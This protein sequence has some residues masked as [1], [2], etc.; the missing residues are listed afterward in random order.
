[1]KKILWV[2]IL[3][4][5]VIPA[6]AA[7]TGP[8]GILFAIGGGRRPDAMMKKFI[9]L[10]QQHKSGRIIVLPMASSVP[11]EV[12]PEQAD[13]L[14]LLGADKAE[15]R[16]LSP[17]D[18]MKPETASLFDDA[19]GVFFSGGVQS[20]LAD[21][22]MGTVVHRKLKTIYNQGAVIGGTSAGAAVMS[23]MMITGDE[24]FADEIDAFATIQADNIVTATGLGF[25]QSV[26]IDQH[27]I[28]RKRHNRLIS[29][30]L[31]NPNKLG[32]GIDESTAAVIFPDQIFTVLGE[33]NIIVY[34][35]ADAVVDQ[36]PGLALSGHNLLLH[37]LKPGDRYN[38][39]TRRIV[40]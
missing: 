20:R 33:R 25:S 11:E 28:R 9:E 34:D 1:M 10:A 18:V 12:G 14:R 15:S 40:K 36:G 8:K 16:I 21:L 26:I 7:N 27:F 35:A 2:V 37:I 13:Q 29:L 30:I 5:A 19:G 23:S 38:L 22:L 3:T 32:I 24:N 17:Q 31:E 39:K 6:A 4:I